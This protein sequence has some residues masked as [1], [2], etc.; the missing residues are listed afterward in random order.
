[1]NLTRRNT[2]IAMG[3]IAAGAGVI[4]GSGAFDAV[5]ADRS[6]EVEV[7]GDASGLLGLTVLN[8]FIAG[9]EEGG[10]GSNDIIFFRIDDDGNGEGPALN[11]DSETRFFEVFE[12]QNN[13]SQTVEVTIDTG[14]A[15]GVTFQVTETKGNNQ[16]VVDSDVDLESAGVDL[17]PSQSVTVD[18]YIDT[19]DDG[20]YEQPPENQAYQMQIVAQSAAAQDQ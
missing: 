3:A 5:E 13:G 14:D 7:A 19:T 8:E 20:G 2:I 1:M 4:G 11:E 12:M 17:E 15:E 18:I 10:A 6:F 9:E 16:D